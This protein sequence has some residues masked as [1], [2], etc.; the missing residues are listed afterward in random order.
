MSPKSKNKLQL[1]LHF[2][3]ILTLLIFISCSTPNYITKIEGKNKPI[4]ESFLENQAV[5]DFIKPYQKQLN[6]D[7]DSVISYTAENLD[8]SKG[9]WQ[10]NI[11]DMFADATLELSAPIFEKR[12]Q[13]KIDFCLLN[14]GG[15]RAMIP[16]GNITKRNAFEVMPFENSAVVVELSGENIKEM[17]DLF[18]K[19]KQ[20]HPLSGIA[21][22]LDKKNNVTE[23]LINDKK[24]D[25]EKKYLVL[26]NDYL[27]NGGGNM[28]FFLKKTAI[29]D[30]DYKLRNILIDYF[31]KYKKIKIAAKKRVF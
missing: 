25:L 19:D 17:V 20:P 31:L 3:T 21:I 29:F 30:L 12:H 22:N 13:R 1:K 16:K 8:K 15:I 26:T 7:L 28:S 14:Q 9:Q 2:V 6:K 23:I 10:T 27:A 4:H 5:I 24:L 11:G 18:V